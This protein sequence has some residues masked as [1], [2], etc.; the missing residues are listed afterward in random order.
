MK[1]KQKQKKPELQQIG[2]RHSS[3]IDF[4]AFINLL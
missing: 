3:D 1:I 2:F 4:K